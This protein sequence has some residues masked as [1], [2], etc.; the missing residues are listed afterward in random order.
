MIMNDETNTTG[1][2]GGSGKHL[3]PIHEMMAILFPP[4]SAQPSVW[5]FYRRI[6]PAGIEG[7]ANLG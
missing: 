2:S 4:N 5:T 1:T 7:G 3:V 6:G